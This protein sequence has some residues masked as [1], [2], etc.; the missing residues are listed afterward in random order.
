MLDTPYK[1]DD[2]TGYPLFNVPSSV[3]DQSV[4][5]QQQ[6]ALKY[7]FIET[8]KDHN[9]FIMHYGIQDYVSLDDMLKKIGKANRMFGKGGMVNVSDVRSKVLTQWYQGKLNYIF[10]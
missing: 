3:S 4:T 5:V 1:V 6:R 7:L 8:L 2:E 9:D 10:E